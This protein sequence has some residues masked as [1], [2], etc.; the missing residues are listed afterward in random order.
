MARAIRCFI[1]RVMLPLRGG[2]LLLR[3]HRLL[4][5][6]AVPLVLNLMLYCAARVLIVHY[7]EE[8][9]GLLFV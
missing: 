3:H 7:Y 9:F 1:T 4:A 5:L 8:W 2:V 6:A